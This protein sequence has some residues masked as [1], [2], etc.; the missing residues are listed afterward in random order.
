MSAAAAQSSIAGELKR[1][2]DGLTY[3]SESDYPVEPF[4]MEGRGRKSL[5]ASDLPTSE[6]P[7]KQVDFDRFFEA[8]TAEADWHGPEEQ[9]AVKRFQALVKFLKERLTG[10]KVYKAGKVEKDVFVAGRTAEGDFAGVSTK[11]VET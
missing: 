9:R 6:K 10:V 2:T 7:V 3:M 11:V 8:A 1:L 4:F 5:K